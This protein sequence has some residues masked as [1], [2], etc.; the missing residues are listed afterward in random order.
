MST[1]A[2]RWT[3]PINIGWAAV[4]IPALWIGTKLDG[5][6]G[7]AVAQAVVGVLVALPITMWALHRA[8]VRLGPIP[9]RLVRPLLA[10]LLAGAVA[11]ALAQVVG[12]SPFLQ[13]AVAGTGGLLVYLATAVPRREIRAA[14]AAIRTT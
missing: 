11:L 12:S 6:R 13:L 14:I 2:T 10:G 1:G 8:G 4:L 3:L 7:A 9:G 5:G